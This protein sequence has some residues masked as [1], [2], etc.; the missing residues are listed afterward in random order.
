MVHNIVVSPSVSAPSGD[1]IESIVRRSG[2]RFTG[3]GGLFCYPPRYAA[4]RGDETNPLDYGVLAAVPYCSVLITPSPS[5]I[6]GLIK[7]LPIWNTM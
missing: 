7:S 5:R 3:R 6:S 1:Q 2:S 4:G